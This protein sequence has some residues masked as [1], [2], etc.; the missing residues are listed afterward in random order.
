MQASLTSTARYPSTPKETD[1]VLRAPNSP[2]NTSPGVASTIRVQAHARGPQRVGQ[3]GHRLT[4]IA[5]HGVAATARHI[6]GWTDPVARCTS[7]MSACG[8]RGGARARAE[9]RSAGYGSLTRAA[10][11]GDVELPTSTFAPAEAER[12]WEAA[13]A[14]AGTVVVAV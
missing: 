6:A 14:G 4:G 3:S 9:V 12:A 11:A 10:L 2:V 1:T 7:A 8:T 5:E 13:R